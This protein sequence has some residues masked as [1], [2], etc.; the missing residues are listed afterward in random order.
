MRITRTAKVIKQT[1]NGIIISKGSRYIVYKHQSPI[2][3]DKNY[4][5][6]NNK[7]MSIFFAPKNLEFG[8]TLP[9]R[10]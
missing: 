9:E 6:L 5:K 1:I 3:L 7:K 4:K 8:V 10:S 2:N